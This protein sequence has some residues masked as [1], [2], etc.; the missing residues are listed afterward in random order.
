[1]TNLLRQFWGRFKHASLR[2]G[3]LGLIGVFVSGWALLEVATSLIPLPDRIEQKPEP[4]VL[5]SDCEE[6][7]LRLVRAGDK[8]F[9]RA[10]S[11]EECGPVFIRATLAA[12]DK[13]FW[14]HHGVDW[15]GLMRVLKEIAQHHRV[16]SGG[17]T[18]TQQLVKNAKTVRRPRNVMTKLIEILQARKLERCWTKKQI[19]VAYL[20]RIDY[21]NLCRGAGTASWFYFDKPLKNLSP[22]EA[23]LLAGLPNSPSRLNPHRHLVRAQVRKNKILHRMAR[24]GW[25]QEAQLKRA[26]EEPVVLHQPGRAFAAAHFVDLIRQKR[27]V[28]GDVQGTLD[29]SL[30]RFVREVLCGHLDRL[31]N[32]CVS[33]GAV[34]VIENQTGNVLCLVGSRDYFEPRSGQVNGAWARRSAGSTFKPFTYL[35]ALEGGLTPATVLADVPT[36]F[37]TATGLFSPANY[38]RRFR[39]PVPLREALANSLNVPAVKVL[40]RLG[41]ARVLHRRLCQLDLSTL[42]QSADY[43][44][45]GLT[46]GNSEARLMELANA[47]AT[48]ARL[49]EHRP[50]RLLN[51]D[52]VGARRVF[53]QEPAWLIA[54]I[55]SDDDARASAFGWQSALSFPFRVACKTGTSSDFRDNWA[56]GYTPEFTVGVWVGNFDGSPMGKVTGVTGSAPVMQG[57]MMYLHDRFGTSWY[58]RPAGVLSAKVDRFSGGRCPRG[59][60]EF[61]LKGT[62]P[63]AEAFDVRDV[64]GKVRLGTEFSDWW[65]SPMNH[66]SDQTVLALAQ[67]ESARILSPVPGTV[68]YLDPD[69]PLSSRQLPL[70][71]SIEG[72]TWYSDTLKCDKTPNGFMAHLKP[73]RHELLANAEGRQLRTWIEVEKQ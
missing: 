12:E 42:E 11:F 66:L 53:M 45:L 48:L 73:G 37:P 70:R 5:I 64:L 35:L 22:A 13:R 8:M 39:G 67:P 15:L 60:T 57:V 43:Y 46:I 28:S 1:M 24:N 21:G 69:L 32:K 62:V 34:V 26:L 25:L 17:S 10:S 51:T 14:Q 18:I 63:K 40:D 2:N 50:V 16:M 36:D 54:D 47:Y 9:L 38:D 56:F 7:P 71:A 72:V 58:E 55:L 20:N 31:Q 61:F 68:V 4:S 3:L 44:G 52:P 49:G 19:L 41:G 33:N 23:A 6:C 65:Q 59:K 29:L 27:T 30:N